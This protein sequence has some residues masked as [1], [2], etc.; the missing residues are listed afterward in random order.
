MKARSGL[1]PVGFEE[2][3]REAEF[4]AENRQKPRRQRG[5]CEKQG[6]FEKIGALVQ[7]AWTLAISFLI[8][9]AF[10]DSS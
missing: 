5:F 1:K 4:Q 8:F 3:E 6:F 10:S 9:S 7:A 2:R